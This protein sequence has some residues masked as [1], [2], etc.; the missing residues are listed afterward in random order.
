MKFLGT[1]FG[2]IYHTS[3]RTTNR[4]KTSSKTRYDL[5]G[6]CM[7]LWYDSRYVSDIFIFSLVATACQAA[8][9]AKLAAAAIALPPPRC[10]CLH[11]RRAV[12]AANTALSPS[13]HL[14]HQAGC[15][16]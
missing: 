9:T 6:F 13:C 16:C 10:R 15:C 11:C 2:M 14:C 4:A 5:G 7:I 1:I 3:N 8:A 12:D